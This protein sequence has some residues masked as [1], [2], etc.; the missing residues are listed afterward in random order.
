MKVYK[1]VFGLLG[2]KRRNL[3]CKLMT[4]AA[5]TGASQVFLQVRLPAA[6]EILKV[7]QRRPLKALSCVGNAGGQLTGTQGQVQCTPSFYRAWPHTLPVGKELSSGRCGNRQGKADPFLRTILRTRHPRAMGGLKNPCSAIVLLIISL[8]SRSLPRLCSRRIKVTHP[9]IFRK[10][11][12]HV[13]GE[14]F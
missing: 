1:Q 4:I 9:S 13:S 5:T 11:S 2:G 12:N 3:Q 7:N 10:G 6:C 8:K 14:R